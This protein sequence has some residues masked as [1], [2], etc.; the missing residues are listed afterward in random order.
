M[1]VTIG[2]EVNHLLLLVRKSAYFSLLII[3]KCSGL[4]DLVRS[5]S[6]Q[7]DSATDGG[8]APNFAAV[9]AP[10][11]FTL[12]GCSSSVRAHLGDLNNNWQHPASMSKAFMFDLKHFDW[13][14]GC[15]KG[16]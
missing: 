12:K 15:D 14:Y 5:Q 2:I 16:A 9:A 7:T 8:N 6:N 11:L 3:C 4:V 1:N 13:I 10:N